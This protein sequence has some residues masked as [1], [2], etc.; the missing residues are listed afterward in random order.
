MVPIA[1]GEVA[2]DLAAYMADSE[3]QQCALGLGVSI[4]RDSSIRAAGGFL[5]QV[6]MFVAYVTSH[7]TVAGTIFTTSLTPEHTPYLRH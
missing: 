4:A 6:A 3:Q 7:F 2:E 1:T 5:V